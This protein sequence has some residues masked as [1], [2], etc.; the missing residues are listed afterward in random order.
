M[1]IKRVGMNRSAQPSIARLGP[2]LGPAEEADVEGELENERTT[3]AE[4]RGKRPR[5]RRH[6][7]DQP[8]RLLLATDF[9]RCESTDGDRR[10]PRRAKDFPAQK[11]GSRS[12]RRLCQLA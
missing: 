6:Y 7:L 3:A 9:P 5:K 8:A 10:E 2:Q 1:P 4:D 12:G 11:D